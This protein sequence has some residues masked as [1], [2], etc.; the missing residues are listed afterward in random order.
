[1][2]W[3]NSWAYY[4]AFYIVRNMVPKSWRI[5]AAVPTPNTHTH[6]HTHTQSSGPAWNWGG[7]V[8]LAWTL[9][10]YSVVSSWKSVLSW[11]RGTILVYETWFFFSCQDCC[12]LGF[13]YYR[14]LFYRTLRNPRTLYG[15]SLNLWGRP[16]YYPRLYY[17]YSSTWL[18]CMVNQS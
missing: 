16:D 13:L 2:T 5:S 1:M 18:Q 6:T 17:T 11:L 10:L 14:V 15:I 9:M 8:P 7:P 3:I 4:L 12:H